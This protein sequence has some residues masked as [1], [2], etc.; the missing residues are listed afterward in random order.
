MTGGRIVIAGGTGL[1]GRAL[2]RKWSSDGVDVVVLS[3]GLIEVPGA[4]RVTWDGRSAGDWVS[5]IDGAFAV[6]NLSGYPVIHRWT[7]DN[8]RIMRDSRVLPTRAIGKAIASCETPP[9]T[10]V[11]ASA[12]GYYG[13]T[14]AREV[15]EAT[16]AG[17]GFLP[18]MCQ[19][20]EQEV[21]NAG[22]TE[23]R[24]VKLRIGVVLARDGELVKQLASITRAFLG[25][26]V[27]SGEQYISWIHIDDVVRIIDWCLESGLSGALN[28]VAPEPATNAEMMAEFRRILKRPAL[29]KP[30]VPVIRAVAWLRRMEPELLLTGQRVRSE[31]AIAN[32]FR[33]KFASLGPA[34]EDLL[35]VAETVSTSA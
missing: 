30:P 25:S 23:T 20:W 14:G 11:N 29:P 33:F 17:D 9:K 21:D 1:I 12:A 26:A 22:V 8:K 27:G 10:W 24:R 16:S 15:S 6:I 3:R 35:T 19:E 18:D 7:A 5:E 28:A 31:I 13:D 4:R 34:L 32:G 2:A